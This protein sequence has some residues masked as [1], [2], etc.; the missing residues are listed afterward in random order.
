MQVPQS[1]Y[2]DKFLQFL[3]DFTLKALASYKKFK[4]E[5]IGLAEDH[6]E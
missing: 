5:E 1:L 3:K 4:S 6:A 2:D